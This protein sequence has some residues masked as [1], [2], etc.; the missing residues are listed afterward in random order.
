MCIGGTPKAAP[1]PAQA[2]PVTSS[3]PEFAADTYEMET[4][5]ETGKK[6]KKGK[7]DL[8]IARNQGSAVNIPG[9]TSSP[10]NPSGLV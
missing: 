2:A 7:R 4:A 5:S 3:A 10:S 9:A 8:R 1:A 6:K